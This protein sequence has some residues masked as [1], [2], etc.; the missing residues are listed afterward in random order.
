MFPDLGW[1]DNGRAASLCCRL[2]LTSNNF[3]WGFLQ[4]ALDWLLFMDS[5]NWLSG[6]LTLTFDFLQFIVG[7]LWLLSSCSLLFGFL[8]SSCRFPFWTLTVCFRLWLRG[9]FA[10]RRIDF[11]LFDFASRWHLVSPRRTGFGYSGFGDRQGR[12]PI[13]PFCFFF[14]TTM[15]GGNHKT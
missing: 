6:F 7:F 1:V 12:S 14:L 5:C 13:F 3:F 8:L 11:G 2:F 9:V 4:F 10:P 15:M